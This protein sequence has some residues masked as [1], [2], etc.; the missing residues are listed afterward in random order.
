MLTKR[1]LCDFPI[2]VPIIGTII[3]RGSRG[4]DYETNSRGQVPKW[5]SINRSIAEQYSYLDDENKINIEPSNR[6]SYLYTYKI[7][8][9]IK[10]IDFT[11]TITSKD[12][13][14]RR[15]NKNI[16][17]NDID[18]DYNCAKII[19]EEKLVDGWIDLD[20]H[21][22][23]MLYDSTCLKLLNIEIAEYFICKPIISLLKLNRFGLDDEKQKQ[24]KFLQNNDIHTL[25]VPAE[26][27]IQYYVS[28]PC[29]RLYRT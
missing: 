24:L 14:I 28:Y 5:Y 19:S 6:K 17:L 12:D 26:F 15:Y 11:G 23:I 2:D 20:D 16:K 29:W 13:Y 8:K 18:D 25:L 7:V 4:P 10:L 9:Q 21:K 3:Y 27:A 22:Q 1:L